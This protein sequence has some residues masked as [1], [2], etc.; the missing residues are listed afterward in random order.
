MARP[1]LLCKH[2]VVVVVVGALITLAVVPLFGGA[3]SASSSTAPPQPMLGCWHRHFKGFPGLH[4]PAGVWRLKITVDRRFGR[5]AAYTPGTRRCGDSPDFTWP[6]TVLGNHV[7][8][9]IWPVCERFGLYTW[10]AAANTLTL[11]ATAIETCSPRRRLF[12]GVWRKT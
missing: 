2:L 8:V 12:A 4:M 5:L 1:G 10:K 7:T 3:A 9:G 6:I 11:Q